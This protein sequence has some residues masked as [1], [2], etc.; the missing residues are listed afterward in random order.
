MRKN[1]FIGSS[2]V[3]FVIITIM[4]VKSCGANSS[5]YVLTRADSLKIQ[6]DQANAQIRSL[7]GEKE[8]YGTSVEWD[9]KA[10][11]IRFTRKEDTSGREIFQI[12]EAKV[13]L[14]G[15]E[16][17][18]YW[19]VPHF[20]TNVNRSIMRVEG[21]DL[22]VFTLVSADGNKVLHGKANVESFALTVDAKG[23]Q[24]LI[25]F[26]IYLWNQSKHQKIKTQFQNG[27]NR[28]GNHA[29]RGDTR[30]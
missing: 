3:I 13:V 5:E 12:L 29:H 21:S 23:K 10:S 16:K 11:Y 20:Y 30:W 2:I 15:A 24:E 4:M 17:E 6:L 25:G 7:T 1:I 14:K 26:D 18:P 8:G 28:V 19:R 27:V 22:Y 9:A